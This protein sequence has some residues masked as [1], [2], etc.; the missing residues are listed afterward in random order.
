MDLQVAEVFRIEWARI[1]GALVRNFGDLDL[2]EDCTQDAFVE[3]SRR[4][5]VDGMPD[6]PGAWLTT[7]AR[8]L[9][10]DRLR[11]DTNYKHKLDQLE[12]LAKSGPVPGPGGLIDDQL[13]LLLGCCHPALNHDAQVA[14]TLRSVAGLSTEQ[15]ARAF[16]VEPATMVRRISRAKQKIRDAKIPFHAPDRSQLAERI[17]AVRRV[18]YLIFTEGH[19]SRTEES[20]VRGDLCDE[21]IWLAGLLA[22]LQP[23]DGECRGL[24]ALILLTDAR[25]ATRL[26]EDG[27]PILLRDQDRSLWDQT[28]IQAGL[29]ALGHAVRRGPL[30][31]LGL[32]AAIASLH[33]GAPTFEQTDWPRIVRM[34]DM[35][36]CL[37]PSPIICLNRAAAVSY[38]EGPEA[39][40]AQI[41]AL[42]R[43]LDGYLYF[44]TARADVLY[45]LDRIDES[46]AAYQAALTCSP[47]P[48]E[49][50]F[51]ER[52]LAELG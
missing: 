49:R 47:A 33:A 22:E 46:R 24:Q 26:D 38:A 4:W 42:H 9:A 5:P 51:V 40:L 32:Q 10:L 25:R 41:D 8:R 30:G 35:L 39:A 20:F 2:A 6:R 13:A 28:K 43:E 1:V 7:T 17:Q 21:A 44:H 45:R 18:I 29:A 14:L 34:Y 16:L 27:A 37:E 48:A 11:R 36:L 31:S 52:R 3:A 23:D 15:I 12:V 19:A 50:S